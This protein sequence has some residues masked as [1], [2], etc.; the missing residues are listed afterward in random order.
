MRI[1]TITNWAY[2]ITV[3]LTGLSGAAFILSKPSERRDD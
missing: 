1:S 3:A 2:G